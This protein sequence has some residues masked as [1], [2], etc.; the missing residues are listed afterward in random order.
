MAQGRNVT[1]TK[2]EESERGDDATITALG[3][4]GERLA[5]PAQLPLLPVRDT[6]VFP[7]VTRPIAVG[8]PKSVAALDQA[9]EHGFL[10]VATQI[11]VET[12]DPG[13]V[14]LH[15]VACIA[16]LVRTLDT[17]SGEKQAIV[18]GLA[19]TR[20]AVAGESDPALRVRL[21]PLSEITPSGPAFRAAWERVVQ[22]VHHVIDQRDDLPDEWKAFVASLPDPG[23]LT[24]LVAAT[25]PLG[26][27]EQM[28]LLS[29]PD[30]AV[31]L[32]RVSAHLERE[33]TIAETQ[34]ALRVHASVDDDPRHR[35]RLLR[36]R[37][38]DIQAE[39][40]EGDSLSQE[41]DAL[42]ERVAAAELPP[43]AAAHTERELK[44]FAALLPHAAERHMMRSYLEWV[45]DLPWSKRSQ[46]VLDLRTARRILDAD[47][48]DLDRVKER[49]LEHLAVRKLAPETAG[50][51]LCFA[52]PPGVGKTS[53]GRS[54]ARAMGRQFVRVSLGGIRDEAEIRGH[55]RTYVGALPG[56]I[57]QGLRR[58]GTRNPVFVLDEIDKVGNDF[59]GDPASAL[60]EAL[61][62]EQNRSFRD[63]YL[64][65]DFD[66]SQVFFI[67]TANWLDPVPAALRD[68]MEVMEL[69]GYT[70]LE[71]CAIA[72]DHLLP[73]QLRAHGL[74]ATQVRADDSV[75]VSAVRNYTR[76]AGVRNLD[77]CIA[78]LLRK[79]ARRIAEGEVGPISVDSGFAAKAL[80]APPHLPEMAG[81][82]AVPGVAMGLAR[83]AHGGEILFVEATAVAGG[84]GVRLR[85][86]GQLGDVMRE[87]AEAA[88]SWV[89]ASAPALQ[90]QSPVLQGGEIHVHLP[91]GAVSKDGPSAGLALVAALV[92]V[93][94]G[95]KARSRV[96]STGEI[97]LR[98]RVLPVGG[99]REKL[100]AAARCGIETVVL[101]RRNAIHLRDVPEE[102]K[103]QL[104]LCLVDTVEAALALSLEEAP[105]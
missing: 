78:T 16:R 49:I 24:D 48:Y 36:Q 73:K 13:L 21:A 54:I 38:R 64:D 22:Q 11:Q 72:R 45:A 1:V 56:R 71:K 99:V 44:R 101:P 27:R 65:L 70:E 84:K 93:F 83:S 94:S 19:R 29:E 2:V 33:A 42:R 74:D 15:P 63:H 87:S 66:L 61:D 100:L 9:A 89:R 88:L 58:A 30:V 95:R 91:A 98:G 37:M 41:V 81:R 104:E 17:R 80:G 55:R 103:S 4:G 77:R 69:S 50:A 47:H 79:A 20:L 10:V 6:V 92:S 8:R 59:R 43:E 82:N 39:I 51:I 12:E 53:L 52:G 14:D 102:V 23:L 26:L 75:L 18:A 57:L 67:T 3:V 97:S 68:R 32:E 28:E 40:G 76:E 5:L 46:D 34:R 35:E 96:A 62:P 7:G 86:T 60:L 105:A 31:R 25:L 85:L 90:L